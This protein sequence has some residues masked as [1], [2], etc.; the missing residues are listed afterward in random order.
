MKRIK[1]QK[2]E[3]NLFWNRGQLFIWVS[4]CNEWCHVYLT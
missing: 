1:E 2:G 3:D 4:C